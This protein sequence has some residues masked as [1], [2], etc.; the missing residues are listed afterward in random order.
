VE[1]KEGA[2]KNRK[3]RELLGRYIFGTKETELILAP[4]RWI[5]GILVNIYP[6][7]P[8]KSAFSSSALITNSNIPIHIGHLRS[9]H[10][11]A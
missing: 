7:R 11:L 2:M 3:W 10:S 6:V 4:R 9:P 8:I 1:A 5:C